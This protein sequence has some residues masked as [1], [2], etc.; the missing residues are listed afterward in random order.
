MYGHTANNTPDPEP[1]PQ[2]NPTIGNENIAPEG[3]SSQSSTAHG[4]LASRAIDRNTNGNWGNAS[5]THT[6]NESQPWWEVDWS[7]DKVIN[8]IRIYNRTNCCLDRLTNFTV[9]VLDNNGGTVFSQSYSDAPDPLLSIN[10]AGNIGRT[11][12]VQ[13]NGTNPLSLAEVEVYGHT[14]STGGDTGGPAIG[15]GTP[16]IS[17]NEGCTSVDAENFENGFGIWN[18]GG[19]NSDL[20]P[21]PGDASNEGIR[22]R[23]NTGASSSSFTDNLDL[24]TADNLIISFDYH[25]DS[26]EPGEDFF[27]EYSINGGSDYTVAQSWV[28]GSDFNNDQNNSEVVSIEGSFSS[29]TRIRFRCDA[30]TTGDRVYIDNIVIEACEDENDNSCNGVITELLINPQS[31]APLI[32]LSQGDILCG[33]DFLNSNARMRANVSGSHESARFMVSAPNGAY[34]SISNVEEFLPYDS[35]SFPADIPGTYTVTVQLY[36]EPMLGGTMCDQL[37]LTF[38]IEDASI[39]GQTDDDGDCFNEYDFQQFESNLG[40][41]N[42]GG[43]DAAYRKDIGDGANGSDG[44]VRLR[45]NSGEASSM[46]TDALPFDNVSEMNVE[47]MY[48]PESFETGEDFFLEYSND[49]G[50]SWNVVQSWVVGIDFINEQQ[51]YS[52]SVNIEG[53]FTNETRIRFRCDASGNADLVFI[54]DVRINI[55]G[56][57]ELIQNPT[58]SSE[59]QSNENIGFESAPEIIEETKADI[60][61]RQYESNED[62]AYDVRVYPNPI[63]GFN[64]F[65]LHVDVSQ[66]MGKK[67]KMDIYNFAGQPLLTHNL[68]SQHSQTT[69]LDLSELNNG[70]YVLKITTGKNE[71]YFEKIMLSRS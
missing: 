9:S 38:E 63:S 25:A 69:E 33:I 24:R 8:E 42:D 22:L 32:E 17:E 66:L 45:D 61:L 43:N 41:W 53:T 2:P 19:S 65:R 54:D 62:F 34:E 35:A 50:D 55:C 10:V 57:A 36:S 13:L 21:W 23:D 49:D 39:C 40:I 3:T 6:N 47:F 14:A 30:S 5:V 64:G 1:E 31:G 48:Y 52:E 12:R 18:D 7:E 51:Y 44:F 27:L 68:N 15:G 26:M 4:G 60:D 56:N 20:Q 70:I 67:V 58:L 71:T 46:F 28:S 29:Q 37:T 59:S 16:T 11:V